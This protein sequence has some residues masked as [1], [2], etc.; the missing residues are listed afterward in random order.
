MNPIIAEGSSAFLLGRPLNANPYQKDQ[1]E[2][3]DWESGWRRQLLLESM[4]DPEVVYENPWFKVEKAQNYHWIAGNGQKGAVVM[5]VRV[6]DGEYQVLMVNIFRH[7][8]GGMQLEI[9]RG[10]GE[11]KDRDA[12]DTA[13]RELSEETGYAVPHQRVELLGHIHT[14]SGILKS[15]LP[16][17][18]AWV[19]E[20][21]KIT[22]VLD[23]VDEVVWM[24][25]TE[26][27][28]KIAQGHIKDS[29]SI[30]AL[31]LFDAQGRGD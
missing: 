19:Q 7:L 11:D 15:D 22:D 23:E 13:I 24:P 8:A 1:F 26:L 2:Y 29:F 20:T 9:P 14:D 5:P 16:Y 28:E 6:V 4:G 21:D 31:M 17:F 12:K 18:L 27:R 10:G 3:K 25:M 30:C